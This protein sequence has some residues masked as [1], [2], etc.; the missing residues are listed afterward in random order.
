LFL[1]VFFDILKTDREGAAMYEVHTEITL[2]N[3]DDVGD[4][5]R[6]RISEK[7]VRQITVQAIV[8]TGAWNMVINEETRAALGLR[9]VGTDTVHLADGGL[10]ECS[11][12]GPVE[13]WWKD[14]RFLQEALMLPASKEILL[15]A[16]PLEAMDLIIDPRQGEIVGAHGN[17]IIHRLY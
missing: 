2:K 14:S 13:V 11:I 15:G 4:A 9:I 7:D 5:I 1:D 12:V 3:G 6:G 10:S 8:D 17:Q 16:I